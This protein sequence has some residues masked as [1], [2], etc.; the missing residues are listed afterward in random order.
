MYVLVNRSADR[1]VELENIFGEMY[2]EFGVFTKTCEV[3]LNSSRYS[4]EPMLMT[5][6]EQLAG[7]HVYLLQIENFYTFDLELND[8]NIEVEDPTGNPPLETEDGNE[9]PEGS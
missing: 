6:L 2:E 1:I 5:L 3:V 9:H 4:N 8:E 7:L